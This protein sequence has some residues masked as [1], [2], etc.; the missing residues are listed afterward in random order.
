M[1]Y[2]TLEKVLT[3]INEHTYIQQLSL[4]VLMI[5]GGGMTY[6]I[7]HKLLLRGLHIIVHKT[8]NQWDDILINH[9][10]FN[11]LAYIAPAYFIYEVSTHL[12]YGETMIKRLAS[13]WIIVTIVAMLQHLVDAGYLIYCTL[14]IAKNKSGSKGFTQLAKIFLFIIG[15]IILVSILIGKS[16]FVLMSGIG[17]MTAVLLL[18]FRDTILALL[19]SIQISTYNTLR[20]GDWIEMKEYSADGDVVNINL[21]TLQVQNWDKTIVNIPTHK[22]LEHSFKNWR[23]M[24]QAGGRRI[25]RSIAIDMTSVQFV[26]PEMLKQFKAYDT[27]KEYIENKTKEIKEYNQTLSS[28]TSLT[29][30]GRRLTNLGTFRAYIKYYLQTKPEINDKLTFLVRQL[31]PTEKGLPIQIYLFTKDTRWTQYEDIQ[32]DI[33][34]H[35]LAV[36]PAFGLRVFQNPTGYDWRQ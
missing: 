30:N 1:N 14:P 33:F 27:I 16:P 9:K 6:W 36:I 35:I 19:A 13:A 25:K 10:V 31:A 5:L 26:T 3:F 24:Y 17:A 7:T 29:I 12:L 18:I 22:F 32:A 4:L 15:A 28:G 2:Q 20:V 23:G 21:H 8:K 34:D 11:K